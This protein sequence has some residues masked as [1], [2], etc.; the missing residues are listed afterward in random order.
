M[1]AWPADLRALPP[2]LVMLQV[3]EAAVS[4]VG[5][6]YLALRHEEEQVAELEQAVA[7]LPRRTP[8]LEPSRLSRM[9]HKLAK[10]KERTASAKAAL[11]ATVKHLE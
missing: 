6:C 1:N 11:D 9:E 2:K 8:P 3:N 4:H 5:P 10:G 7:A